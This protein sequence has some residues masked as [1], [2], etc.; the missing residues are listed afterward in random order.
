M[1]GPRTTSSLHLLKQPP[2]VFSTRCTRTQCG[3]P[4]TYRL[5][6]FE[7]FVLKTQL[8]ENSFNHHVSLFK[9]LVIELPGQV[10]EKG[11]PFK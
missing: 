5:Y 8:F 9:T 10:A 6:L 11:V 7:H 2:S 3:R 4:L 1:N